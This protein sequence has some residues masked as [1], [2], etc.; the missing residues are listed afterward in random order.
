MNI[1]IVDD[2]R[3]EPFTESRRDSFY[4]YLSGGD[5]VDSNINIQ[6]ERSVVYIKDNDCT[7]VFHVKP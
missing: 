4:I 6:P 2:V 5:D 3:A 7:F 1:T